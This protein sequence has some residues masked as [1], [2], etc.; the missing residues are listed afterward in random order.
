LTHKTYVHGKLDLP[1][2]CALLGI[3]SEDSKDDILLK[4]AT[5]LQHYDPVKISNR[6]IPKRLKKFA[7]EKCARIKRAR[8]LILKSDLSNIHE[9]A[10]DLMQEDPETVVYGSDPSNEGTLKWSLKLDGQVVSRPAIQDGMLFVPCADSWSKVPVGRRD[11]LTCHL[12]AVGI[13]AGEVKWKFHAGRGAPS[14]PVVDDHE[15]YFTTKGQYV[16]AID[17][18]VPREKWRVGE[19]GPTAEAPTLHDGSLYL[20]TL[21][22]HIVALDCGNGAITRKWA[23]DAPIIGAPRIIGD[24]LYFSTQESLNWIDLKSGSQESLSSRGPV[25]S[26]PAGDGNLICYGTNHGL[27]HAVDVATKKEIW[28]IPTGES[29]SP[30]PVV[31]EGMMLTT[32]LHTDL[33]SLELE[34]GT[35]LWRFKVGD[36]RSCSP[37]LSE[38]IVYAGTNGG[39]LIGVEAFTGQEVMWFRTRSGLPVS[40]PAI[41][42][43]LVLF[44]SEDRHVYAVTRRV[45][46]TDDNR[47]VENE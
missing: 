38:G 27:L 25:C 23:A 40:A 26:S 13:Q 42:R 44:G 37:V 19:I 22:R 21:D 33:Y 18:S 11:A 17:F 39:Q 28:T 29:F 24:A 41:Y 9:C 30:I 36:F 14:S 43:D 31:D 6:K 35:K 34:T 7:K 5:L 45:E 10:K 8:K 12:Y 1:A 3:S 16:F 4:C 32:M 2:A 46:L 15:V 47:K 20:A